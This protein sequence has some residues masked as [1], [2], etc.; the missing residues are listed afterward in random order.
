MLINVMNVVLKN[1]FFPLIHIKSTSLP[2]RITLTYISIFQTQ[3]LTELH[4][5]EKLIFESAFI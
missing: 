3:R 1:I 5:M 2:L 4:R